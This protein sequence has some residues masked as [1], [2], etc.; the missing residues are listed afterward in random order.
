[1]LICLRS[2]LGNFARMAIMQE[3]YCAR[4]VM[5]MPEHR[6]LFC[7]LSRWSLVA[8]QIP[9]IGV[10]PGK[11]KICILTRHPGMELVD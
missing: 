1:M 4:N 5:E 10:S 2:D 11:E 6:E 9:K 3:F 8:Y 7:K